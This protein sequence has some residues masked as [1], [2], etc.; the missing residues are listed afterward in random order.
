MLY[1]FT[2]MTDRLRRRNWKELVPEPNRWIFVK[3]HYICYVYHTRACFFRGPYQG[4]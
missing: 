3:R 1:S 2:E 4:G